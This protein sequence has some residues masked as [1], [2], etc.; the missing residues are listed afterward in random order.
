MLPVDGSADGR[1]TV[2]ITPVDKSGRSG[3]I[4]NR[5][6]ILDTQ[7]PRITASTPVTLYQPVSYIGDSLSYFQFTV[8]D[9]GPALLD[10]DD[11][12]IGFKKKSGEVVS[13][14][15]THDGSNQLF[16]TLSAPL[17]TDGSADG[18]Y[19]LTVDLVDKA[20]NPYQIEHNISYDSQAPQLSVVSLNTETPLNLTPYQVTDLSESISKLTLNFV[21][22]TRVDFAETVITL[23]SSDGSTVPLTLENNGIDQIVVSF[24]S[25]TQGGLYT[26]SVTPQD[27]AGNVAQG[28]VPY[29]FRLEFEVPRLA[30][31]KANSVAASVGLAQHEI[32]DI[33]ESVSSLTLEFTDAMRVDF[34]NTGVVLVGPSGQEIPVTLEDN[35]S[36]Q[37]M[38]RFVSLTQSGLYMLSVTPQDIAGNV[39][40]SAMR[41]QFRLDIALPT[42]SSVLIDGKLGT[43]V[44]ANNANI[45]VVVT[46]FDPTGVGLALGD[47]GSTIVVTNAEGLVVSGI[48]APNGTNE[49]TWTPTVLPVDGS[50]DGRYTVTITPVDK[51]GRSGTIVNRHFILDTQ[52]PHI[53]ASTPVTLYQ[54]VSYI[55]DSLSYFQFT[56]EDVGPALLDLDDQT[57]VLNKTSGEAVAGQLTQR[58]QQPTFLYAFRTF[59]HRW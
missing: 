3:T 50:A 39:A 45:N 28:A 32:I 38:V 17:P 43:N 29:P 53:T 6:F 52:A 49:L 36:S 59:T 33:S 26:L 55:G 41:Y 20:G 42:V 22:S 51:S 5:H 23:M 27:I 11:Q 58:W 7:A 14:Q 48:I 40:Q 21:E 35:D 31:V 15:I 57:I 18:E 9:A 1:Y 2:T 12:T 24:V 10:L 54:S 44:Y 16:F 37:L 8:E 46:L 13:G 47:E 30:S 56:V 4:V 25:L 34:K 19:V